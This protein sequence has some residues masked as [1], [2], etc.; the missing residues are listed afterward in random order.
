[1]ARPLEDEPLLASVRDRLAGLEG[2][3]RFAGRQNLDQFLASVHRDLQELLNTRWCVTSWPPGLEELESSLVNYGIPDFTGANMS[4]PNERL[5]FC[6]L[7]EKSIKLHD[8]RFI[9]VRLKI[10]DDRDSMDR[11]FRF[12]IEAEVQASP[13]PAEVVFDSEVDP[14]SRRIHVKLN[15]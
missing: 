3:G 7:V 10:K 14:T 11:I 15:P 1:M 4:S 2:S 13:E 9:S 8:S 6:E 5:L 12:Q